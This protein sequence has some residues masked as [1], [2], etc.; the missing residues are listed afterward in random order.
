M[1]YLKGWLNV[2]EVEARERFRERVSQILGHGSS[3]NRLTRPLIREGYSRDVIP[4]ALSGVGVSV[5]GE[6]R[7]TLEP[8]P[9][10]RRLR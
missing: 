7:A 4:R 8:G 1:E 2:A 5:D 3:L 6:G 9:K 10:Q